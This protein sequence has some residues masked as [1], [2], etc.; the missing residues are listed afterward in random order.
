MVAGD[1]QTREVEEGESVVVPGSYETAL[2]IDPR[3]LFMDLAF[4]I[5]QTAGTEVLWLILI[6]PPFPLR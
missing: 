4:S 2:G 1:T 6:S 3:A 5:Y